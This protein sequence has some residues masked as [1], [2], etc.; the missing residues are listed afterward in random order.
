MVHVSSVGNAAAAARSDICLHELIADQA[1]RSP[2]ATALVSGDITLSYAAL[3]DRANQLA[4]RLIELG[5]VPDTLVAVCAERGVELIVALLGV[6]K[7]GAAY[8][9]L[10][11]QYPADRLA[12]MLA[13]SGASVV[14]AQDRLV[15]QMP[16]TDAKVVCLEKL[17]RQEGAPSAPPTGV[18][19]GNLAYGIYTSGTTGRPKGVL[20]SHAGVVNRL[21]WMQSKYKLRG[22]DRVVQKTPASFDVAVWEFFWPLISGAA[23]VMARPGG[24]RDPGYLARLM[25]EQRITTVHFVPSMLRAFLAHPKAGE[26]GWLRRAFC[27]GE[28]LPADL[29]SKWFQTLDVDLHNL[30][31]PTEA[32]V[33][34]THWNCRRR[35]RRVPIGA[36]VWN[37]EIYVLGPDLRPVAPGDTGELYIAGLQLAR[38]YHGQP[39][40]TAERFVANPFGGPGARMYRT[41]DLG[42]SRGGQL[43]YV[44]RSD[45][46]VKIRGFRVELA[47]IETVLARNLPVVAAVAA[48]R[49][50][51]GDQRLVG[52][53][54]PARPRM[55]S[56]MDIRARLAALLPEYM[57]PAAFVFLDDLP[58]TPNGKVDRRSLPVPSRTDYLDGDYVAPRSVTERRLAD[59]WAQVLGADGVGVTDNFFY[60]G[61]NSL[62][63]LRVLS[64]VQDEFGVLLPA[65][66]IFDAPTVSQL[67]AA[68]HAAPADRAERITAL[69]RKSGVPLSPAQ[70]RFWLFQQFDKDS[71]EYNVRYGFRLH[72]QLD[73]DAMADA[74]R[75][76]AARHEPL[77]TTIAP[78]QGLPE[79]LI[80]PAEQAELPLSSIDLRGEPEGDKA[81][82]LEQALRAEASQ[83]F[84]LERGPSA[85]ML[86]IRLAELEHILV[87]SMH[88]SVT[89]A[90]SVSITLDELGVLYNAARS[91]VP[92]TLGPLPLQYADYAAWQQA[93]VT[94][95]TLEAQL[96][97]WRSRLEGL[98]PLELPTDRPRPVVKTTHG[99]SIRFT[100]PPEL[101]LGLKDLSLRHDVTLFMTLTAACQVILARYSGQPDVA[102][103]TIVSG[104][105]NPS[106]E[107]LVGC[108]VNTLVLRSEIDEDLTFPAFAR[109]VRQTVLPAFDNQDIPFDRVVDELC[110]DRDPARLPLV[111]VLVVFQNAPDCRLDLAGV[112]AERMSLPQVAA[113]SDILVEFTDRPGGLDVMIQYNTDLYES[114]TIHRLGGHLR[115]FLAGA[116]AQPDRPLWEIPM[117]STAEREQ[118]AAWNATGRDVSTATVP[119]LFERQAAETPDAVALSAES[120]SVSYAELNARANRLARL[121]A[122]RGIGPEKVVGLL[123][124]RSVHGVVAQLAV[125]KAG[126]AFLPIHPGYPVD[127][128]AFMIDD[129]GAA[130]TITTCDTVAR[131]G[132]DFADLVV[133]DECDTVAA[134]R[135]QHSGDL[136]NSERLSPTSPAQAA[137]VIYTSGSTGQPKGVVVTHTGVPSFL[138]TIAS[139]LDAGGGARVLQFASPSFDASFAELCLS[140]LTGATLVIGPPDGLLPGPELAEMMTR[141]AVSH[142]IMPP[143]VLLVTEPGPDIL[144]G[145]YLA[146]AGEAPSGE[147]ISRWAGGRHVV[148]AY[149]PT[150]ST[151]CTTMSTLLTGS[152]NPAIGFPVHNTRVYVL[153]NRLRQVPMGV[154]GEAYAAGAGLARG[155][156]RRPGLTAQRFV[157]DPYGQPGSRMYRTGDLVRYRPDGQLEFLGRTDDQIKIRGYRLEPA[158]V[159][160]ALRGHPGV[161]DAVVVARQ[162]HAAAKQL[163]GYIVPDRGRTP[164]LDELRSFV[165]E[166]L[167]GH[168][169]PAQIVVLDEIPL[170]TSGKVD[171]A[172]L[173]AP[174]PDRTAGADGYVAPAGQ[175]EETLANIWK[176]V[177]G[178]PSVGAED[179][180]FALGGD[181]ILAIQVV[182]GATRAGLRMKSRDLFLRPTIAT[183]SRHVTTGPPVTESP[184]GD[185]ANSAPLTPIQRFIVE[186]SSWP[187]AVNQFMLIELTDELDKTGLRVAITGIIR[188]H[189]ALLGTF[190]L[191]A[192]TWSETDLVQLPDNVVENIELD[193]RDSA[194]IADI[195]AREVN[196]AQSD[197]NIRQGPLIKA[198]IFSGGTIK[199]LALIISHLVVDG[200]SWRIL[201]EDLDAAYTQVMQYGS[202]ELGPRGS[203]FQEWAR[204]MDEYTLAG[205][206]DDEL[207]FWQKTVTAESEA[208]THDYPGENLVGNT[209][210]V[211][212]TL[213]P[214]VTEALLKSVPPVYRTEINDVLIT[215][216][217]A[218][219]AGWTGRQRVFVGVEGH[220]RED[221]FEDL[222]ITR[223]VGW[224]T[225]YFPVAIDASGGADWGSRL[226]SIKEQLRAI[227]RRGLGYGALRYG[228]HAPELAAGTRPQVSFNYLGQFDTVVGSSGLCRGISSINLH[229]DPRE[230]RIHLVD[231]IGLVRDGR[232]EFTWAYSTDCFNESTINR[233][234]DD[235]AVNL[236]AIVQ[237]CMRPGISGRTPSDFALAGL[238]QASL[239]AITGD[240]REV[241]DI[242]PLTPMQCGILF[243]SLMGQHFDPYVVQFNLAL[244]GA[245]DLD[246][247]A[248]AWQDVAERTD[249]LRTAVD[250]EAYDI[251]LQIVYGNVRMPVTCL[252]WR[253]LDPA[254]QDTAVREFLS[255]DRAAGF[256]LRKPPLSRVTLIRLADRQA[257]M[258]WTVH[259]IILDGWSGFSVLAELF[260]G[261]RSARIPFREYVRWLRSRDS[262]PAERYWRAA[263]SG[264][265]AATALPYDTSAAPACYE[266]AT[267]EVTVEVTPGLMQRLTFFARQHGLTLNT[268]MQAGWAL[269]LARYSG[270]EDVCFGATA[271]GRSGDLA[272][273]ESVIGVCIS[274]LPVRVQVEGGAGVLG[275]LRRLQ[276]QQ[277]DARGFDAVSLADMQSWQERSSGAR[278]F[279]SILV[280]ENYPVER[281]SLGAGKIRVAQLDF[282]EAA[283]Y[284]LTL[285]VEVGQRPSALLKYAPDLFSRGSVERIAANFGAALDAI[286]TGADRRVAELGILSEAE[287]HEIL[288]DWNQPARPRPETDGTIQQRFAEQVGRTPDA[289]AVT[290]GHS[291]MTYRE[292]DTRANRLAHRLTALGVRAEQNVAMLM[293]RSPDLI[294]AT[295]AVLKAGGAYVPL[296]AQFPPARMQLVVDETAASVLLTDRTSVGLAL[297]RVTTV[298]VVDDEPGLED[299]P[300][301]TPDTSGHAEQ[302]AYVMY[303]SGS[304]GAPKGVAVTHRD[305]LEFAFDSCWRTGNQRKVLV[306]S[307][308]AFDASTY[309]LWVP[310]LLGGEAVLAPSGKTVVTDITET[311][312]RNGVTSFCITA[313]LFAVMAEEGTEA[314]AT[315]REVWA[316]G[317]KVSLAAMRKAMRDCPGTAL[318]H[319]YGPTETTAFATYNLMRPPHT[320]PQSLP[321][322]RP[323]NN[324]RVYVLDGMLRPVPAGVTGELYVAG[325]GLARGYITKPALTAER[326]VA[327]P[328]GLPATCMYRTGDLVRWTLDG[329]LEFVG[330]ADQQVKI[331]GH[332]IEPGEIEGTLLRDPA[333][334]EAAVMVREEREGAKRIVAYVVQA[335]EH[336]AD[337]R[338]MLADKLPAYMI[339]SVFVRMEKLPLNANGKVDRRALPDPP[340]VP[341]VM[342]DRVEP[343][344]PTEKALAA[345]WSDVLPAKDIGMTDNFFD[346]GGDSIASLRILSRVR[347]SFGV[348]VNPRELFDA[349]T[350]AG[351]AAR[352]REKILADLD[353]TAQVPGAAETG[354]EPAHE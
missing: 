286:I 148:N 79:Q 59:I 51:G 87:I 34:V 13:D 93:R 137:Y 323:M 349:P 55:L 341:D 131:P 258:I 151:I 116:L 259:H 16:R 282:D 115:V 80:K 168:M 18:T 202:F 325:T 66:S 19:A 5:V 39:G 331:Y 85:R 227:P 231:V 343:R 276:Q 265:D 316:G 214:A 226:K 30:Y 54:V 283:S 212:V 254:A 312:V 112:R 201:L 342:T 89:D 68:V 223:T 330:R 3:D 284:P 277:A 63:A 301:T 149:G 35:A 176:S 20:V 177:L 353:R 114:D 350:V 269:L 12:F 57:V 186:G 72:G 46:Q 346:L 31:G 196:R 247:L 329:Q 183:L 244:D 88:H 335:G 140:L 90:W 145:G 77:R 211:S 317:E 311:V 48:I 75:Q 181:S 173:P 281:E 225:S 270:A 189:R 207:E 194:G 29:R 74:G 235:F 28:A 280:L 175:V 253:H 171:K 53:L 332:R 303:T 61:G 134:L 110:R 289:V 7:A 239:D 305:V 14:L 243:D 347:R 328:Y 237:H 266:A 49:M 255:G 200:I 4:W 107:R 222:D 44:G 322:G 251:P 135:E 40:L 102:V 293:E 156:L 302:L 141:Q 27:S 22:S 185:S 220:G 1:V 313:A 52:Y 24:H 128:V 143:A 256:D 11:P 199:R 188:Q 320:L 351:L 96:G 73:A 43:E 295:L 23:L 268:I 321:V 71:V 308:H 348:D 221:L 94:D 296:D 162:D 260:S 101:G 118:F 352:L 273:I 354:K 47:E 153:D 42:R 38:G 224:F 288:L 70:Q 50:E 309:E 100:L 178:I 298:L 274:T 327:D 32:T 157:A 109:R 106:L 232:M 233:L 69:G 17:P 219:L 339:P 210:A 58:L 155:Y 37:T 246:T 139:R 191:R 206:F 98:T 208:V 319:V 8:L 234:A 127:R 337:F 340:L 117:L 103:G 204:R 304:T 216:L 345:I 238:D 306:Y 236:K 315:V 150:E 169:V 60:L 132:Y 147:L 10:D 64:R 240:G 119:G 76:L 310:L 36:P 92:A 15:G 241:N 91:G 275:W 205:G 287:R 67:A 164:D 249:V 180:F 197:I 82:R 105:T 299:E 184:A 41:G 45:S 56:R 136:S 182:A 6:L 324:T 65:E 292:L 99:A 193:P 160:A 152:G 62:S 318:L 285:A 215:A 125:L 166:S 126:A 334:A 108:F 195:I 123:L 81:A 209:R 130:L 264:L 297:P 291:R 97:F 250:W 344:N 138:S 248:E 198:V 83:P 121:L 230:K 272:G 333:V 314:L 165:S 252:D 228:A 190:D 271:S 307:P 172:A 261:Q 26:C 267:E 129:A 294:V 95:G 217:S 187:E 21:A 279:D 144:P 158:E 218:V 146:L 161:R 257:Q 111:Q 33:D 124:P 242:Y 86:L 278:L 142:A 326:F 174:R 203:S 336:A 290:V 25:Q 179:N 2:D 229:Q 154:A 213:D 104:R 245:E 167:P 78:M 338:A 263:L 133:I 170:T 120:E 262:E 159:Q 122:A 113:V 192:G 300:A 9:P 84:D 163:I